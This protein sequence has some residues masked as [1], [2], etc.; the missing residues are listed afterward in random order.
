MTKICPRIVT[1]HKLIRGA[2]KC[3]IGAIERCEFKDG[4]F[5]EVENMT[6]DPKSRIQVYKV[7]RTDSECF[8]GVGE[9]I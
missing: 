1:E 9:I 2:Q 8:K 4:T 7:T 6:A 5:S 3:E